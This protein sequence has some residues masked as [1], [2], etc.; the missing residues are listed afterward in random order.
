V[1]SVKKAWIRDY[2]E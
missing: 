2:G 1:A